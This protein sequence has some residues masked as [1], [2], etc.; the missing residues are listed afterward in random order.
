MNAGPVNQ[1]VDPPASSVVAFHGDADVPEFALRARQL[2]DYAVLAKLHVAQSAAARRNR[3]NRR[4]PLMFL[5]E[6]AAAMVW[7]DAAA[8]VEAVKTGLTIGAG[9]G[10]VFALL[11]AVLLSGFN[12]GMTS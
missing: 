7:C 6:R 3:D 2:G 10:G 5:A 1:V 11:L 4:G 9:T 8:R 12:F